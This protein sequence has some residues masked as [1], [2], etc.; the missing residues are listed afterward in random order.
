MRVRAFLSFVILQLLSHALTGVVFFACSDTKQFLVGIGATPTSW[1]GG[2]EIRAARSGCERH[3]LISLP[4]RSWTKG[5]PFTQRCL[6]KRP[7]CI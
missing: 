3:D 1:D 7:I 4:H 6:G 2:R 5:Q